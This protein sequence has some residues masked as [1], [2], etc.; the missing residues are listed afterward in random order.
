MT[1][2]TTPTDAEELDALNEALEHMT[3][4][5]TKATQDLADRGQEVQKLLHLIGM[6]NARGL[7]PMAVAAD[8]DWAWAA[9]GLR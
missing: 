2:Y 9:K 7:A 6:A 1:S 8:A 3:D 4:M 5:W